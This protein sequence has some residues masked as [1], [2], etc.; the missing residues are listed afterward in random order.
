MFAL[1]VTVIFFLISF[2]S[3]DKDLLVKLNHGGILAGKYLTTNNGYPIRS[4]LG[5]PYAKPPIEDLRFEVTFV[6]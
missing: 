6:Q 4:F 3:A 1:L 5:V 2:I